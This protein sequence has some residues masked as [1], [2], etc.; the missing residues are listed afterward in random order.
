MYLSRYVYVTLGLLGG[1][2]IIIRSK[3]LTLLYKVM[4][5]LYDDSSQ[6]NKY[7]RTVGSFTQ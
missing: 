4:I 5:Y 1:N 7:E 2:G 6:I 3:I